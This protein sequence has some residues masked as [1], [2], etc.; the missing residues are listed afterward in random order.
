[1]RISYAQN[2]AETINLPQNFAL[3]ETTEIIDTNHNISS[4]NIDLGASRWNISNL[5]LNFSNIIQHR[6]LRTIESKDRSSFPIYN[7]NPAKNNFGISNQFNVTVPTKIYGIYIYGKKDEG[8]MEDIYIQINGFNIGSHEP[9]NEVHLK[10]IL[11]VSINEGWHYQNFSS[12]PAYLETGTYSL[13]LNGS[14]ISYPTYYSWYYNDL[15]P[16][17]PNL[18][19]SIYDNNGDWDDTIQGRSFLFKLEQKIN[20]TY[21]PSEIN[22]TAEINSKDIP[23]IDEV[24]NGLG[25]LIFNEKFVPNV[26]YLNIPIK[27]NDSLILN[28]TVKYRIYL[29]NCIT[30]SGNLKIS[31]SFNEWT[32]NFENN[33]T[34]GNF[35]YK[36]QYPIGWN[37]FIISK[38][39]QPITYGTDF[40]NNTDQ[41][42]LCILNETIPYGIVEWEIS[43]ISPNIEPNLNIAIT[44]FKIGE[45]L[46]F[47]ILNQKYGNYTYF[48]YNALGFKEL[49]KLIIYQPPSSPLTADN[50]SYTIPANT[51]SGNWSAYIFWNNGTDAGVSS[52]EFVITGI[53]PVTISGNGGGGGGGG[54]TTITGLDPLLV[55]TV[56]I[57]IIAAIAGSLTSYQMV[58]KLKR[59]R[60]LQ[61]L[62]LRNKVIDSLNLNY[63]MVSENSSG[64]NVYEQFFGG[65]EVDPTL[66][67][68]F[69]EAIRS[70][71]IELTGTFQ[72]SQ[73]I[74]LD[75]QNSKILMNEFRNFRL[76]LIMGENP[77][78]DFIES[79]NNL[80]QDVEKEYGEM[81][82]DFDGQLTKFKGIGKLIER[83]LN[84]S[85]LFPLKVVPSKAVKLTPAENSVLNKAREII[86]QNNLDYIFTSFLMDDQT[87][88]PKRIK[89][90]FGLIEKGIFQPMRFEAQASNQ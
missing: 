4:I 70:F 82:R 22:M 56:S 78:D 53:S 84:V 14:G 54:S 7:Y 33:R 65:K 55:L 46:Q 73:T 20:R 89:A 29:M 12:S 61:M 69:L 66:I 86:K 49:E 17:D 41:N 83:N 76:I 24:E 58:K 57:I 72:Q 38:N 80:S 36:F 68:G 50:F 87:Y 88:E 79:I 34:Y 75:F 27:N 71:G 2:G 30:S 21:S 39:G 62:K 81:I 26:R 52:Q 8:M 1:M 6:Q 63:I 42:I 5:E 90:I 40:I 47:N 60:D 77:S 37:N 67:S 48:L 28:F 44:T 85:F 32:L 19:S 59:K 18:Y 13:F 15:D 10:E 64:L 9:T 35:T 51:V 11:D 31:Q 25:K 23:I 16:V 43:A 45:N 3:N 74:K